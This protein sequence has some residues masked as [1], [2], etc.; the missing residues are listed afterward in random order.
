MSPDKPISGD[1]ILDRLIAESYARN[2]CLLIE[3]YARHRQVRAE[4]D[5]LRD[6]I[7]QS[8][9][10]ADEAWGVLSSI[11]PGIIEGREVSN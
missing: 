7:E 2:R 8:R 6:L 4:L 11:P 10:S 9:R 5:N 3:S 1:P